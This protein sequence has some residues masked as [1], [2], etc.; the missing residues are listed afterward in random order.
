MGVS[1]GLAYPNQQ[2]VGLKEMIEA[3]KLVTKYN[4]LVSIHLRS[5]SEK[6]LEAVDEVIDLARKTNANIEIT[7]FKAYGKP[8]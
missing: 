2:V 8:N 7:H 1:F 3:S 6:L 5:E 4:G